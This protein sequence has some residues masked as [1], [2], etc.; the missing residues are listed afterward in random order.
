MFFRTIY[1]L[2][3]LVLVITALRYVI[4]SVARALHGFLASTG[5]NPSG[6]K[7]ASGPREAGELKR[8]PVCGT[9]VPVTSSVTE[10]IGGEVVHFCSVACRDRYK[11]T[12]AG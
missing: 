6:T 8:D 10:T 11:H 7:Q 3:V 4:G 2:L 12:A 9:F 5:S 1:Y